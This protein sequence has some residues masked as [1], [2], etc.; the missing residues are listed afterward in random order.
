[1]NAVLPFVFA[2]VSAALPD[3]RVQLLAVTSRPVPSDAVVPAVRGEV[4]MS[5]GPLLSHLRDAAPRVT[6]DLA[7]RVSSALPGSPC[8]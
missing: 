4:D 5:T 2:A 3:P 6:V 1:M 7:G 8:R